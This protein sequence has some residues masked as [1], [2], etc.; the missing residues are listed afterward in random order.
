MVHVKYGLRALTGC[1]LVS[2]I[3][4]YVGTIED[5]HLPLVLNRIIH[6]AHMQDMWSIMQPVFKDLVKNPPSD[7]A[8]CPCV[9]D[10]Q[11][12]GV[13]D[14]LHDMI[15]DKGSALIGDPDVEYE[16]GE[17]EVFNSKSIQD[18]WMDVERKE[19]VGAYDD[20]VKVDTY[21]AALFLYCKL[22]E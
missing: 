19:L 11:K 1:S 9:K 18:Y 17:V 14:E 10:A 5:E 20:E 8:L 22:R 21:G 4:N 16:E 15:R 7:P 12:N 6:H 2:N 13:I 3:W